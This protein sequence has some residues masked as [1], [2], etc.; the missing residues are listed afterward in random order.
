MFA[1]LRRAW[2]RYVASIPVTPEPEQVSDK[3][4]L[5]EL[6]PAPVDRKIVT[7]FGA[8]A[9]LVLAHL[10]D[11][12]RAA[13]ARRLRSRLKPD[14]SAAEALGAWIAASSGP[15]SRIGVIALDWKAR[16]EVS[17]QAKRLCAAHDVSIEWEY[18]AATDQ[19][20]KGWQERAEAPVESPLRSFAAALKATRVV[21]FRFPVDDSVY[22]FAVAQELE[23][24]ALELCRELGIDAVTG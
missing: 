6:R 12:D 9:T 24:E 21:L 14:T 1:A 16:E 15:K 8:L 13:Q 22:A 20:W 17:W 19:E 5:S 23:E 7:A 11:A 2:Q 4:I 3:E 10:P 18:D